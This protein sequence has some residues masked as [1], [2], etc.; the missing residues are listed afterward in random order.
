MRVENMNELGRSKILIV[1][2]EGIVAMDIERR[3]KRLG[4]AVTGI[5]SSGIDAVEVTGRLTPDLVLMDVKLRGDMDGTEA[6]RRIWESFAIP[7]VFLTAY[8]DE[9][10]LALAKVAEPY[11]YV[12]NPTFTVER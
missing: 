11:G 5:A 3:L 4:Y 12:V 8:T 2:D 10:T 6:A 9:K 1:E 7:V